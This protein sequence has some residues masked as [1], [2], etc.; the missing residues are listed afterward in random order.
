MTR[1]LALAAALFALIVGTRAAA[2]ELRPGAL[3]LVETGAGQFTV[4]WAAP[5]S[6]ATAV[7][8][9]FPP[10][11]HLLGPE[12][13]CGERGLAGS[14]AVRGL[15]GR[16]VRVV[17]YVAF[18]DGTSTSAVLS[19][20]SPSIVLAGGT[21]ARSATPVRRV[22]ADY[23]RMGAEHILTGFDHLLFVLG[24]TLL[25]GFGRRLLITVTA[26]TLAH[27]L[28]LASAVLG[29]LEVPRAPVEAVIALSILLLAVECA[30]PRASLSRQF[31][32]LVAFVFGLLHG[33]GF[34]GALREVGLPPGQVPLA[35][36]FFNVGIELGQLFVL[37]V[38][39]LVALAGAQ[40]PEARRAR[41]ERGFVYALGALAAYWSIERIVLV[42]ASA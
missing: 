7:E 23:T 16:T 21:S 11:C 27:S 28:T 34:A 18:R 20:E 32:W 13:D 42:F 9:E 26:F 37:L 25:V 15:E 41:L 1:L 22:I 35:L 38:A 6:G 3:A 36:G 31:P 10:Q 4:Q 17:V 2:H 12:L 14:I 19:A 8:P 24:L 33:F 30:K 39:W 40:W 5:P 29:W